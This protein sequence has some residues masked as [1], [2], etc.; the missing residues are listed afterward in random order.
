VIKGETVAEWGGT[1][2][3]DDD[4]PFAI[5]PIELPSGPNNYKS[6]SIP[7][8]NSGGLPWGPAWLSIWGDLWDAKAEVRIALADEDGNWTIVKGPTGL[9]RVPIKSGVVW[10][11]DLPDGCRGIS[12]KRLP[13]GTEDLCTGSLS[14]S[15]EYGKR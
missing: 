1:S 10:N 2:G 3:E 12:V 14:M 7:P 6:Y 15:I 13:V 4:M 11:M 5:G 9:E 8:V